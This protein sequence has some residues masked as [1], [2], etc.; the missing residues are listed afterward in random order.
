MA[1]KLSLCE[2]GAYL[3][4]LNAYVSNDSGPMHMAWA[5][6]T[7]ITA[8]FGP[9]VRQLGFYPRGEA[10]TV[11]ETAIDCRPCGLHGAK[12]CP[13]KHHRCMSEVTP[14]MVW[15]DVKQKLFG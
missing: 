11:L 7:P 3:A 13:K 6:H 12:V 14:D 8:I 1:G 5:Q 9:T 2:L 15:N 4:R 10:S